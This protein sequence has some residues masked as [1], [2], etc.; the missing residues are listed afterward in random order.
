MA[1][2]TL[3]ANFS[4]A[5]IEQIKQQIENGLVRT[6]EN[7]AAEYSKNVRNIIRIRAR[8]FKKTEILFW[9]ELG[10][11]AYPMPGAFGEISGKLKKST[12][13]I[14]TLNGV[15][16]LSSNTIMAAK[17]VRRI[18]LKNNTQQYDR[19]S[20][21]SNQ[22]NVGIAIF[23][24]APYADAVNNPERK[25]LKNYSKYK[26]KYREAGELYAGT[27]WFDIYTTFLTN[28][29]YNAFLY[30]P[31]GE[32]VTTTELVKERIRLGLDKDITKHVDYAMDYKAKFRNNVSG[33][34]FQ[35][36]AI[37]NA[38]NGILN[39]LTNKKG[40]GTI[41]FPNRY[42]KG[43]NGKKGHTQHFAKPFVVKDL[44]ININPETF[45]DKLLW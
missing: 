28:I 11:A 2:I 18:S 6:R 19:K 4:H 1:R 5:G 10:K 44:K 22:F 21:S 12:G 41:N 30:G 42:I 40:N 39:V 13:F 37:R 25:T 8:E 15:R 3:K 27:G 16:I 29:F 26:G 33:N 38:T 23:S 36:A 45:N 20:E 7:I 35:T 9:N 31:T 14:I 24:T 43:K 32:D 34:T 17:A